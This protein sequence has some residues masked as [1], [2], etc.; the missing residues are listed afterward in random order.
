[1][2]VLK[3]IFSLF[4]NNRFPLVFSF[5][6]LLY[7]QIYTPQTY[8]KQLFIQDDEYILAPIVNA[9][10]FFSIYSGEVIDIQ[11]V[12]DLTYWI[13]LKIQPYFT[14]NTYKMTNLIIW[15]LCFV[16]IYFMFVGFNE[17]Y[18]IQISKIAC[19]VI[20]G[21]ILMHPSMS[22][23]IAWISSRK[24]LLAF[25]FI[26]LATTLHLRFL[27][28]NLKRFF[29][30]SQL[31][32]VLSL[33]SHVIYAP[34]CLWVLYTMYDFKLLKNVRM[35]AFPFICCFLGALITLSNYFFYKSLYQK[36]NFATIQGINVGY[37][38]ET[39]LMP[40]LSFGR[41]FINFVDFGS[42]NILY[43]IKTIPNYIGAVFFLT[44]VLLCL[45]KFKLPIIRSLMILFFCS[46][47]TFTFFILGTF[48]QNY[49]ALFITTIFFFTSYILF[50]N[51][52]YNVP[53]LRNL[54][55]YF[56][57]TFFVLEL[58]STN[59]LATL[60]KKNIDILG[61]FKEQENI[62]DTK[63][64]YASEKVFSQLRSEQ[65][66]SADFFVETTQLL[67]DLKPEVHFFFAPGKVSN[68]MAFKTYFGFLNL[69]VNTP[70]ISMKTKDEIVEKIC[71][72]MIIYCNFFG[73][74]VQYHN[75]KKNLAEQSYVQFLQKL[76]RILEHE[77]K[78]GLYF[79]NH[80]FRQIWK[81][82]MD[83]V[84]NIPEFYE[85]T[86]PEFNKIVDLIIKNKIDI[87]LYNPDSNVKLQSKTSLEI[88]EYLKIHKDTSSTSC[89]FTHKSLK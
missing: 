25:M 50:F 59:H 66:P 34:W 19:L 17:T 64:W 32:F 55:S 65:I 41:Y 58:Y 12:R 35:F 8:N 38:R 37:T 72:P 54:L 39:I 23:P 48:V 44:F 81:L 27:R 80:S 9:K 82:Y 33:L 2:F 78:E 15:Y 7:F 69:F 84:I 24:H 73:G 77:S 3:K 60:W 52:K 85:M 83:M 63:F 26:L 40:L 57:V 16:L 14:F 70:Y 68:N 30:F 71:N 20:A 29:F 79:V 53:H 51:S 86:F 10:D 47:L 87:P 76:Y 43:H 67:I 31:A 46:S 22:I 75:N 13:D 89:V 61:Y 49:Y 6:S 45:K 11:P 56:I 21:I 36:L 18:K 62:A 4:T 74:F 42:S 28:N 88:L 1:M 5:F